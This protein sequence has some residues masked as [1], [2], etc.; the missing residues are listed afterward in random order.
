MG[1]SKL[2]VE[3]GFEPSHQIQ[4]PRFEPLS[5]AESEGGQHDIQ[6]SGCYGFGLTIRPGRHDGLPPNTKLESLSKDAGQEMQQIL[7][8]NSLEEGPAGCPD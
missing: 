2:V 1:Y 5:D 3:P 6:H 4:I 8:F 7:I